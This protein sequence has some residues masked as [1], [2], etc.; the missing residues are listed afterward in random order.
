[1][2]QGCPGAEAASGHELSGLWEE[3]LNGMQG[4]FFLSGA[5]YCCPPQ[6]LGTRAQAGWP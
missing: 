6:A 2:P 5:P 1:M 4:P 3:P